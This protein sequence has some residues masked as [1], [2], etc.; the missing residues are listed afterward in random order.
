MKYDYYLDKLA[1]K[2]LMLALLICGVAGIW[3]CLSYRSAHNGVL[4][5][6]ALGL[7]YSLYRGYKQDFKEESVDANNKEE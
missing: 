5:M 1:V 3:I 7:A 6:V 2:L 4:G